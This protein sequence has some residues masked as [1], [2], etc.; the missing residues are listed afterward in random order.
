M[1]SDGGFNSGDG[2]FVGF[3]NDPSKFGNGVWNADGNL[4]SIEGISS[5]S[6]SGNVDTSSGCRSA[7]DVY[8][9]KVLVTFGG[10]IVY[11]VEVIAWNGLRFGG[12]V[13]FES[14]VLQ[15]ELI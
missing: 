5:E 11:G 13:N 6:G 10:G 3:N 7:G 9:G 15:I 2:I 14:G 12:G 8:L 4:K 1:I